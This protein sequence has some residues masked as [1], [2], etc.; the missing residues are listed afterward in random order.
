MML[1]SKSG[2]SLPLQIILYVEEVYSWVYF[3]L[4]MF[5]YIIR[6]SFLSYP[7]SSLN[8]ELAGLFFFAVVQIIRV[9]IG[10]IG[11]KTERADILIW[12]I[13]LL[14]PSIFGGVFF[15]RLQ[16]Y[17]LFADIVLNII[18]LVFMIIDFFLMIITI[19]SL[20]KLEKIQ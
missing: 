15:I 18:L 8:I 3:L 13:I 14:I 10:S 7:P 19:I 9:F 16:V 5:L 4:E 2:C 11:N 17:V 1:Q 6:G 20:K 12:G